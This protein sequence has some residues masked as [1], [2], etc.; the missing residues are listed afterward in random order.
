[1]AALVAFGIVVAVGA[2]ALPAVA[3]QEPTPGPTPA[4][5]RPA[6]SPEPL[7]TTEAFDP[8]LPTPPEIKDGVFQNS[9]A[10]TD[11]FPAGRCRTGY[12]DGS[13]VDEGFRIR[14]A[15]PCIEP[16]E[17]ADVSLPGRGISIGDGDLAL[18]FKVISGAQ[19]AA[20]SVYVRNQSG[21][22]VGATFNAATGEAK[23]FNFIAGNMTILAS[24]TDAG[25]LAIPS[26]WNRLAVR[27]RGGEIWLL[28]ND[29]P[30]LY[31]SDVLSDVGGVGVRLLREGNP[32]DEDETV[33]V[34]RDLTLS[35][36]AG[37]GEGRSPTY[38]KP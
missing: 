6:S 26:D 36:V 32:D 5:P 25:G 28:L 30:L 2:I 19:R 3:A 33:V 23:L 34:L 35:A 10:N 22:L 9:L 31:A 20:V 14:V 17:T 4:A 15:G 16:S 7:P 11:V 1:M 21:K 27:V 37:A 13:A 24:R 18:D 8:T 38:T 29:D 12:A